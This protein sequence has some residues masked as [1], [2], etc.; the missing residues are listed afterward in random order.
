MTPNSA[1]CPIVVDEHCPYD[2]DD[3]RLSQLESMRAKR[4]RSR[5]NLGKFIFSDELSISAKNDLQNAH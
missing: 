5:R 2:L 3:K 1:L 4:V